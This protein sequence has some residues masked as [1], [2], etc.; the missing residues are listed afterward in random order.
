MHYHRSPDKL[1][2]RLTLRVNPSERRGRSLSL[3]LPLYTFYFL[4]FYIY[5]CTK[6]Q[7]LRSSPLRH[8]PLSISVCNLR[9][10]ARWRKKEKERPRAWR[11]DK[12]ERA[13]D[14]KFR[15]GRCRGGIRGLERWNLSLC[16][17]KTARDIWSRRSREIH[18]FLCI[19]TCRDNYTNEISLSPYKNQNN[20]FN[21]YKQFL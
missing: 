21:V 10:R 2:G 5:I 9:G 14:E 16:T 15:K 4:F 11:V 8:V 17:R 12:T 3:P 18:F 6:G 1:N 20:F 19:T 7:P 13:L